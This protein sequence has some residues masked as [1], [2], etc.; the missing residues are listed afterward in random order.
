MPQVPKTETRIV[1][2]QQDLYPDLVHEDISEQKGYGPAFSSRG[3]K[4][5]IRA[6]IAGRLERERQE[7]K[8][9]EENKVFAFGL[10]VKV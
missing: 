1:L 8:K 9:E 2:E 10:I 5:I 4:S 6:S 3:G 7:K